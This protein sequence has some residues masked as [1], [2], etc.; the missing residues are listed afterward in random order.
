VYLCFL[1]NPDVGS[2]QISGMQCSIIARRC[3]N[4]QVITTVCRYHASYGQE[5]YAQ[6]TYDE[7][8]KMKVKRLYLR[9]PLLLS[10]FLLAPHQ[11]R[12]I[13]HQQP[14]LRRPTRAGVPTQ[15]R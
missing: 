9:I 4:F 8:T 14:F 2:S 13:V 12:T 5:H 10:V 6:K 7:E 3:G 1:I 11:R 15:S